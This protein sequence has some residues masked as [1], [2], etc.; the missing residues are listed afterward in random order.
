MH[1]T[2]H[3]KQVTQYQTD[4]VNTVDYSGPVTA[5][6][7][8]EHRTEVTLLNIQ[9]ERTQRS[10]PLPV[11]LAT[12]QYNMSIKTRPGHSDSHS[13]TSTCLRLYVHRLKVNLGNPALWAAL[14]I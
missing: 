11:P 2:K 8:G 10:C 13:Q 12:F 9:H 14:S 1:V 5:I 4:G 6:I 3:Y 7:L